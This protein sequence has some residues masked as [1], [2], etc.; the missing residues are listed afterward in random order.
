MKQRKISQEKFIQLYRQAEKLITKK[1]VVNSQL[2]FE[3][4]AKLIHELQTFQI[5]LELQNNELR[6]SQQELMRSKK[7]YTELYDFAPV[8]YITLNDKGLILNANLTMAYMLSAE[9]SSLI[10]QLLSAYIFSEDQD[11][12]YQ[13]IRHLSHTKTRQIC[14]LRLKT[15]DGKLF[16]VQMESTFIQHQTPKAAQYRTVIS[17]ISARKQLEKEREDLQTRLNQAHKME[18]ISTISG[19]IAHDFNNILF[20][21]MGNV[22]L[23]NKDIPKWNPAQSRLEAIRKASLRA[24]GIVNTLLSFNHKTGGEQRLTNPVFAIKNALSFLQESIPA[25]IE[26]HTIFPNEEISFFADPVQIGQIITNLCTNASQA[27]AETGGILEIKV[28]TEFLTETSA[29]GYPGLAAGEYVKIMVSDNGPGIDPKIIDQIFDPYFTTRGL[30]N[31]SGMGLAVVHTIVKN[32]KGVITV[33]SQLGKGVE[34]TML[35][36]MMDE[37]KA[38]QLGLAD[39]L[40]SPVKK[41]RTASSAQKSIDQPS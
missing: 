10:N 2:A 12:Y 26:I 31:S 7:S 27:M 9:K 21:I 13:H 19:G 23:A 32:H 5:E 18:S 34:F 38:E 28:N 24:V 30:C 33:E 37:K 39:Y 41:S 11:I 14:E 29:T 15:A 3:D 6:S 20:I 40:A 16:D 4:P 35:F 22:E 25:A 17:N 8:G 36:P 1:D